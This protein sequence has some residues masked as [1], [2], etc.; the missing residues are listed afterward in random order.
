MEGEEREGKGWIE[1]RGSEGEGKEGVVVG[2]GWGW[3]G[4]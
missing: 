2:E 3:E 4:E 1:E